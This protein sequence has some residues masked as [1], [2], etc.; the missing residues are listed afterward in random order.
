MHP[1]PPEDSSDH[2]GNSHDRRQ[3]RRAQGQRH[4]SVAPMPTQVPEEPAKQLQ[5]HQR[6]FIYFEYPSIHTVIGIVGGFVGTFLDARFFS[7]LCILLTLGLHRSKALTGI[8]PKKQLLIGAIFLAFTGGCLF[9]LGANINKARPHVH[10]PSDYAKALRSGSPIPPNPLVTQI[11]N[12]YKTYVTGKKEGPRIDFTEYAL[13][14]T[15]VDPRAWLYTDAVNH[16]DE[17]ALRVQG[18]TD[19]LLGDKSKLVEDALFESMNHHAL[20]STQPTW[21]APVGVKMKAPIPLKQLPPEDAIQYA[22]GQKV[23]YMGH[24]ERYHDSEGNIYQS[25]I[26]MLL[27]ARY[28][29]LL[30]CDDHNGVRKLSK[31][32]LANWK[33]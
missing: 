9:L 10:T 12:V 1:K 21:D 2:G 15:S 8:A 28:K 23:L 7:V 22:A 20:D 4:E 30:F 13:D 11:T 29:V 24:L 27:L 33:W 17:P 19:T 3:K 5:L 16:G 32:E 18:T 14:P 31:S 26:C 25:E 6:A